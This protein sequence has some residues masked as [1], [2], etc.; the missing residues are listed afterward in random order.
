MSQILLQAQGKLR[1]MAVLSAAMQSRLQPAQ[2]AAALDE[3]NK[4][5]GHEHQ[6]D[7]LLWHNEAHTCIRLQ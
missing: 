4:V 7:G 6:V 2:P 3:S 5:S 1:A